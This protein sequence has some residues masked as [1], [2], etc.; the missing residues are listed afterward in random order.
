V[1]IDI[2]FTANVKGVV[3]GTLTIKTN[4]LAQPTRTISLRGLGT[5]GE[6][7]ANEPS[8]QRILDLYQ[9]PINV[10]DP[11]PETTDYPS[12]TSVAGSEEVAIQ[13]LRMAGSG[14]VRIELLASMGTAN[15]NAFTDT[16]TSRT[17]ARSP[18]RREGILASWAPSST[19]ARATCGARTGET[20][21]NRPPASGERFAFIR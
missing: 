5:V 21:G 4:D 17:A 20:P 14:P 10:A 11:D 6:G 15:A 7:G 19:S 9:L 3:S 8:L 12:Q 1:S 18:S 16:S 13:L 2:F